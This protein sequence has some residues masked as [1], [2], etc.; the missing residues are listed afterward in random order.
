MMPS[1][2]PV[3]NKQGYTIK[4]DRDACIT[5]AV[6]LGV[7]PDVFE[8]DTEGKAVIKNPDGADIEQLLECAKA[9]PVNAIILYHPNGRR[10][11]PDPEV[12]LDGNP[13]H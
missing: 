6:C 11:W 8:L 3:K 2:G 7:A 13:L 5:L 4:V 12:D 9:C 10:I 1:S